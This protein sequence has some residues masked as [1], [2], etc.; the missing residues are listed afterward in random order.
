MLLIDTDY[1]NYLIGY[2]CY[3]NINFAAE[4]QLEPVHLIT[5]GLATRNP[6]LED[7]AAQKWEAIAKEKVP[8]IKSETLAI[9]KQGDA[10]KC[11]Y[12]ISK[13]TD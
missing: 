8:E 5:L 9:I 4:K 6:N 13:P 3:D 12:Q 2:Q 10:G 1:D 7:A 11:K